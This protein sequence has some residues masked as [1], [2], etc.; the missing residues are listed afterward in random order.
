MGA[1][2]LDGTVGTLAMVAMQLLCNVKAMAVQQCPMS[3]T[4]SLYGGLEML[5]LSIVIKE[6]L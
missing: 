1:W 6:I 5:I 4:V 2:T 3:Y